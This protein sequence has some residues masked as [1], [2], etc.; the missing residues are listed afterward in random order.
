MYQQ[1]D[2]NYGLIFLNRSLTHSSA[3]I[4]DEEELIKFFFN[5]TIDTRNMK[6][7]GAGDTDQSNP[8]FLIEIPQ[9][10]ISSCSTRIKM[11]QENEFDNNINSSPTLKVHMLPINQFSNPPRNHRSSISG[12]MAT[13]IDNDRCTNMKFHL[14]VN[15]TEIVEFNLESMQSQGI[16]FSNHIIENEGS[17]SVTSILDYL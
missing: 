17:N 11:Y 15:N 14:I 3:S 10:H 6:C 4:S 12:D 5:R 1:N 7:Y 9:L 8:K 16:T 13:S 2:I